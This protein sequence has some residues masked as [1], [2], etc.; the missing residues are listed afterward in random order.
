MSGAINEVI[1]H[2]VNTPEAA[3]ALDLADAA[4]RFFDLLCAAASTEHRGRLDNLRGAVAAGTTNLRFE[5]VLAGTGPMSWQVFAL[6][7]GKPPL[8]VFDVCGH[9]KLDS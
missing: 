6:R 2:G 5:V 7:T 4:E 1:R 9:H 3:A 8:L